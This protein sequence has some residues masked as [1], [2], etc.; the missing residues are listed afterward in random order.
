MCPADVV[1]YSLFTRARPAPTWEDLSPYSV[2]L[3]V[4][5]CCRSHSR[6]PLYQ[7][8]Q[9]LWELKRAIHK[10]CCHV[11]PATS[12]SAGLLIATLIIAV[13]ICETGSGTQGHH[14]GP[15]SPVKKGRH[16]STVSHNHVVIIPQELH[17]PAWCVLAATRSLTFDRQLS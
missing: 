10:N 15:I 8:L 7:L 14:Q 17:D 6:C 3:V 2:P 9:H 12:S 13:V 4:F 5:E 11:S 1:A 16:W